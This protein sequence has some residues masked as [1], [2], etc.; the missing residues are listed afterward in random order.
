M[1]DDYP[2]IVKGEK[3]NTVVGDLIE[4]TKEELAKLDE[5]ENKYG[6]VEVGDGI[7]AYIY[8]TK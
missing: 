3:E 4:L 2:S 1:I 7:Q 6:R 8:K 5:W